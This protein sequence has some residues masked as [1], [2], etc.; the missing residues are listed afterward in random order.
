MTRVERFSQGAAQS[1]T[2]LFFI[3][4]QKNSACTTENLSCSAS[5]SLI[6][7]P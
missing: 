3:E 1:E 2:L 7:I 6:F 4:G 5:A